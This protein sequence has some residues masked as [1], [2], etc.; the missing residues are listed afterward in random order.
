MPA[1]DSTG[2]NTGNTQWRS[3]QSSLTTYDHDI[4]NPQYPSQ[5]LPA[6]SNHRLLGYTSNP[7]PT[8]FQ[9][10]TARY[11]SAYVPDNDLALD[12]TFNTPVPGRP[13]TSQP[14]QQSLN[15]PIDNF[16]RDTSHFG[17]P[18]SEDPFLVQP[19]QIQNAQRLSNISQTKPH[20]QMKAGN[21]F[22]YAINDLS[23]E[24]NLVSTSSA[25]NPSFP[26]TRSTSPSKNKKRKLE[27]HP[28]RKVYP[29]EGAENI[30]GD[31]GIP[32]LDDTH[33]V[34][35]LY[36]IWRA[37]FPSVTPETSDYVVMGE[38]CGVS[39]DAVESIFESIQNRRTQPGQNSPDPISSLAVKLWLCRNP[40]KKPPDLLLT[41]IGKVFNS[42]FETLQRYATRN[43]R[44]TNNMR[45]STIN[46]SL[47]TTRSSIK[48]APSHAGE[49]QI[50]CKSAARRSGR[51]KPRCEWKR[52]PQKIFLCTY[53][54]QTFARK[55]DWKR[56]ENRICLTE[57][58][59]CGMCPTEIWSRKDQTIEHKRRFHQREPEEPIILEGVLSYSDF[60]K[61][62][63][64][65][66]CNSTFNTFEGSFEH[67]AKCFEE[68]K[69]WDHKDLRDDEGESVSEDLLNGIEKSPPER[70]DDGD[71]PG[72]STDKVC[73]SFCIL[74]YFTLHIY[75]TL[76]LFDKGFHV[77]IATSPISPT[78]QPSILLPFP[79]PACL[80]VFTENR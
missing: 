30:Q 46:K 42:Q 69:D 13:P 44:G 14:K 79:W 24:P 61:Q 5:L 9:G 56:H 16:L 31:E 64:F 18:P 38:I 39:I 7:I 57:S 48:E 2:Y 6:S 19:Y 28:R 12:N 23:N 62:C 3:S 17:D 4:P 67:R 20:Q 71:G 15:N 33:I 36:C 54:G 78:S 22:E 43:V 73:H 76:K 47:Y 77:H 65:R 45:D 59:R 37:A 70:H 58:W 32:R 10:Q 21:N 80:E 25:T 29:G 49:P 75:A 1:S 27:D 34:T 66:T 41:G 40:G 52:D 51:M 60:R 26:L 35:I 11:Q 8:L 55:G 53:C 63:M 50:S 74:N 72:G 68:R